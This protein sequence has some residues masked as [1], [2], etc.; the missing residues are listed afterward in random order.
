MRGSETTRRV[1]KAGIPPAILIPMRG[2]EESVTQ[3]R[4]GE[5]RVEILI[6]MRGSE[7]LDADRGSHRA[8]KIL[9]PMRGSENHVANCSIRRRRRDP[10]PHEG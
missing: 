4:V 8:M 7:L 3:K 2:S 5:A 10:D 9:I 1:R 6:P